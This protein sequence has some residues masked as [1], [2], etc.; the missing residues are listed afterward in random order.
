MLLNIKFLISSLNRFWLNFKLQTQLILLTTSIIS[1]AISFLTNWAIETIQEET[2]INDTRFANDIGSLL[3]ANITSLINDNNFQEIF[4]FCERFYK[5]SSSIKYIIF[6]SPDTTIS[7]GI[8]FSSNEIFEQKYNIYRKNLKKVGKQQAKETDINLGLYSKGNLLGILLVGVNFNSNIFENSQIIKVIIIAIFFLLWITLILGTVFNAITITRPI[9]ELVRGVKNI[10]K[11]NFFQTV[12]LSFG[13][14]LGSLIVSFNEMGRKLQKYDEKNIEKLLGEKTKLESLISTIADGA[15]LLNTNLEI[16]LVNVAAA[17]IFAWNNKKIVTGTNIWE[18][19]PV[20]LQ[21]KMFLALRELILTS[22]S[23]SFYS[24]IEPSDPRAAKKFICIILNIVYDYQGPNKRPVGI[25]VT[26]QDNTKEFEFDKT[27]NQFMSNVS[28]ELRTP[29]FNIRSFIETI[30][31]YNYTLSSG[32]KKIFFGIILK[33]TNRLTKL[34]NDILDLSRLDSNTKYSATKINLGTVI[35]QIIEEYQ[36]QSNEKNIKL[37]AQIQPTL[38][39]ITG[40]LDLLLQILI[41]LIGNSLKFT[42][43]DGEILIRLY[44]IQKVK[45]SKLRIEI[46]DTG[47]GILNNSKSTI[48]QRFAR[49]ENDVHTITGTGLGL[50]I[51]KTTLSKYNS[52]INV[53][54][55]HKIGSVFWFD[56]DV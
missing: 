19:L 32:Q 54:S 46:V 22:S 52:T 43:K 44:G 40:N 8:P 27:R 39:T 30:Q 18:Y 37:K 26:I 2:R 10:A 38:A 12:N 7:Y 51:V 23:T 41:N 56:L 24:E 13:G 35:E 53:I 17:K 5:N 55:K 28:H 20:K 34:V 48:F 42:H 50:S 3:G 9:K 21:K 33:E 29:L 11:G 14:E 25:A 31:E 1:I 49:V 4:P 45:T 16:I 15:L 36:L 47:I 6:F